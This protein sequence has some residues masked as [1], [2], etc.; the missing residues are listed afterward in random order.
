MKKVFIIHGWGGSPEQDWLQ[1]LKKELESREFKVEV[2]NMPD[3]MKPKIESW[4]SKLSKVVGEPDK[5]TY[6]VGHS[7]GCQAI[8]RYLEQLP[9]NVKIG[10]I[11]FVAGWFNLKDETWDEDYTKEIANPWINTQIDFEKVKQHTNKF[12]DIA[13]NNDPY[14][15]LSDINIFKEKLGAEIIMIGDKGHIC[16]ESGVKELPVVLNKLLEISR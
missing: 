4:V 12:I 10:G 5:E 8:I 2:P 6:F 14:V 13:S 16:E 15:P 11:I 1:W 3:S 7:V 9:E